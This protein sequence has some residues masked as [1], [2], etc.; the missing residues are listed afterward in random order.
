MLQATRWITLTLASLLLVVSSGC[1]TFRNTS[2][3]SRGPGVEFAADELR[4]F[5]QRQEEVLAALK[6]AAGMLEGAPA[7]GNWDLII[8]AGMDYADRQCEGYLHALFRLDRDRRTAVSQVGLLGT[9][10]AG[11]MAAAQTAAKTVAGTAVIFGLSSASIENLSSNLLFDLDPSSIRTLVKSLQEKYRS[12]LGLG[13][14]DRPA[15]MRAIRSYAAVCVPANIE[16]EVNLA[17][18]KAQP[19]ASK[20]NPAAGRSPTVTNAELVSTAVTFEHDKASELLDAF[21]FPGGKLNADNQR[22]LENYLQ[23]NGIK[24]SVLLFINGANFSAQRVAA[25]KFLGLSQ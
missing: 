4:A 6:V 5:T 9:A 1:A 11:L 12:A 15:A 21:V 3:L 25:M 14:Q 18:K 23:A 7:A 2:A 13:Y 20:A 10:T 16:A 22:R 8:A 17:V 19:N 24:D